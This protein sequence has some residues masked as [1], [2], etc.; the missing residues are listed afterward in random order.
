[1]KFRRTKSSEQLDEAAVDDIPGTLIGILGHPWRA[2]VDHGGTITPSDGSTP[3]GWFIAAEDRWH[4]PASEVATRQSVIEGTPV[5]ET[6][7]RVPQGDVIQR[8]W[9]ASGRE[10]GPAVVV[11][12]ENDSARAVAIALTRRDVVAPRTAL[13]LDGA[14]G[15]NLAMPSGEAVLSLPLGHRTKVRIA[16]PCDRTGPLI[17]GLDAGAEITSEEYLRRLA[18]WP[19]VV[20]G[21]VALCERASRFVV[22]DVVDGLNVSEVVTTERC[23]VALD[24]P[25]IFDDASS[26][27][28]CLIGWADLVRMGLDTPELEQVVSAVEFVARQCN[29]LQTMTPDAVRAVTSASYLLHNIV[30]EESSSGEELQRDLHRVIERALDRREPSLA[31]L[32]STFATDPSRMVDRLETEFVQWSDTREVMLCPGG[33]PEHRLGANIEIHGVAV[34]P[35][36]HVSFALRWHG[37]RPAVIWEVTGPPGLRL[38]SGVDPT[39]SSTDPTGEGLWNMSVEADE[40]VSFS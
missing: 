23:R 15:E 27:I 28:R 25:A 26:A 7:V 1:M 19:D 30:T 11:E 18:D 20:R 10:I 33:I 9:V 36:H 4:I 40:A 35:E 32:V 31:L 21:W 37:L 5:V 2:T 6:R 16:V 13:R 39:W 17:A 38:R 3:L 14:S 12:F 34:G 8:V 29:R 24:P 22:P